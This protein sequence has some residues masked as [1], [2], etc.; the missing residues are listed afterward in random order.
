MIFIC[1]KV[2]LCYIYL[3]ILAIHQPIKRVL[4]SSIESIYSDSRYQLNS[5]IDKNIELQPGLSVSISHSTE[6]QLT[7]TFPGDK[8]YIHLNCLL[9]GHF[10]ADVADKKLDYGLDEI[11]LGYS[12]GA[13]FCLN[14]A[15]AFCNLSVMISPELL[16]QVAEHELTNI[17]LSKDLGLFIKHGKKSSQVQQ[18]LLKLTNLLQ[19]QSQQ[20][21]L[22]N[23]YVLDFIYWHFSAFNS[24]VQHFSLSLRE[25]RQMNMAQD[26]LLNDLTNPPTIAEIARNIGVNQ[27]KLK[28]AFKQHFG[29]SIYAH[30][31]EK[32]MSQAMTLLKEHNVTETAIMLGYSNV[33]H[34]SAAFRKNFNIL[35]RQARNDLMPTKIN[36]LN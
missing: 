26:Y 24:P 10:I 20:K 27:C 17:D 2:F 21:L 36:H 30:F 8:D 34:F 14:K 32:R 6:N 16:E 4:M 22:L 33:S 3:I 18:S 7:A 11:T 25:Q 15:P 31:L 28:K 12:N 5:S 35:P 1:I 23:A 29:K 13:E 9:K 19:Q